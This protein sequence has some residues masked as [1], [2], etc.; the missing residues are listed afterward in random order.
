MLS[1]K[2]AMKN[3]KY[4]SSTIQKESLHILANKVRKK[5]CEE[6]TDVKFCISVDEAKDVSNKE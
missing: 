6:V 3:A 4:T 2:K 5:I 1:Y